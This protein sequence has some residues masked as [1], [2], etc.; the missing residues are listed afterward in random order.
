MVYFSYRME[1]ILS[2]LVQQA[3]NFNQN[4]YE[5]IRNCVVAE[6]ATLSKF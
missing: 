5:N 3:I 2:L 1:E 4:S 6:D